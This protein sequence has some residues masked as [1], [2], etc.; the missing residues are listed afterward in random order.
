M[1][2][3]TQEL[4][5]HL[6]SEN[7]ASGLIQRLLES[8]YSTGNHLTPDELREKKEKLERETA[9]LAEKEAERI[10]KL[11]EEKQN[12]VK[13]IER[14]IEDV[15]KVEIQNILSREEEEQKREEKIFNIIN[16]TLEV[17]N[18]E[19]TEQDVMEYLKGDYKSIAEFLIERGLIS[20]PVDLEDESQ[21][22]EA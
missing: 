17:F 15:E 6:K 21:N 5:N 9:E 12:E 22:D 16:N 10:K 19:I 1:I 14:K 11:L 4:F 8:Y 7:N 2:Y 13:T 18:V 3:L 20:K